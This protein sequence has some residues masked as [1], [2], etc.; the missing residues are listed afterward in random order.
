MPRNAGTL[1]TLKIKRP[2][3]L[4]VFAVLQLITCLSSI[5]NL[6]EQNPH[7]IS[8]GM[9]ISGTAYKIIS[10]VQILVDC[11][12]AIGILK[13]K[14]WAYLSYFYMSGY[15]MASLLINILVVDENFLLSTGWSFKQSMVTGYRIMML[16]GLLF[17][18]GLCAWLYKYRRLFK[19]TGTANP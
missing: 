5:F 10:L 8:Y 3:G 18:F 19:S 14:R 4:I 11:A 9:V 17:V 16:V 6:F 13:V 12:I 7:V 1:G 15:Y 2:K